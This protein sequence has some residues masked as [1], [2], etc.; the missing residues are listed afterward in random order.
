V[1][2]VSGSSTP[3]GSH[4]LKIMD[5]LARVN[6]AFDSVDPEEFLACFTRN[7]TLEVSGI[8]YKGH[9]ELR[10]FLLKSSDKPTHRH[11]TSNIAISP[12]KGSGGL[13]R[14]TSCFLYVE[15]LEGGITA[16]RTGI[17]Q[18]ELVEENECWKIA[19]RRNVVDQPRIETPPHVTD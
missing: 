19:S 6:Q 5:L 7:A 18:D 14:C 9:H 8:T 10:A 15:S 13:L 11:F 17:Y 3:D 12:E 2:M 4:V 16:I 1:Q